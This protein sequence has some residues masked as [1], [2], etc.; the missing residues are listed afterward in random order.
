M[1]DC[2]SLFSKPL[3]GF[4]FC[5]LLGETVFSV[6]CPEGGRSSPDGRS[7]KDFVFR[8]KTTS[9]SQS[10]T[11]RVTDVFIASHFDG[12][13]RESVILR[14]TAKSLREGAG[15]VEVGTGNFQEFCSDAS[16]TKSAKELRQHIIDYIFDRYEIEFESLFSVLELFVS[17][18]SDLDPLMKQLRYLDKHG[19]LT[20]AKQA[21][22]WGRET[23]QESRNM[24]VGTFTVTNENFEK[25]R[26]ARSNQRTQKPES[27]TH[28][29]SQQWDFFICHASEDKHDVVEPL[30]A[31]LER[32][33][34]SVWLDQWT[35][36]IGDSL[37]EKIDHGLERSKYGVVVL[38]KS[39]FAKKWTKRELS[40]LVQKEVAGEKVILPVWHDVDEED[41]R[42]FSLT[43]VDKVAA[44]TSDGI[45]H[46]ASQLVDAL[47]NDS[48]PSPT[49]VRTSVSQV[50]D[51]VVE[52]KDVTLR[53]DLHIYR[54]VVK[55]K[56]NRPPDQGRLRLKIQ[57]PSVVPISKAVGIRQAGRTVVSGKVESYEYILDWEHR[58]FAGE[59]VCLLG[60]DPQYCFEYQLTDAVWAEIDKGNYVV[61]YTLYFEDHK[62]ISGLKPINELHNY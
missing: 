26:D 22:V 35:L 5:V 56:L 30:A 12:V 7:A 38:S 53:P 24:L 50:A 14:A 60:K 23:T 32:L 55:V 43:L 8:I 16:L 62:P 36:S 29:P 41:V 17:I 25:L 9:S 45:P 21:G 4:S 54:L 57:W 18:P 46:V 52:R 42:S 28:N 59:D 48:E 37:S 11:I 19:Y 27:E 2:P 34:C 47:K 6:I 51:I 13:D 20:I 33:G 61:E 15:L 3:A 49:P 10:T 40:G 31:E 1:N 58:V 39:F 44:R